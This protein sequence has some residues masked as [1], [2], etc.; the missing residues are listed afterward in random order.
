G[1]TFIDTVDVYGFGHSEELIA[2]VLKERGYPGEV[3]VATKAGNDFH[4]ELEKST[5]STHGRI[6][7]FPRLWDVDLG[8][9]KKGCM[10]PACVCLPKS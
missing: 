3:V 7:T 6:R 8:R 5:N 4:L 1:V 2:A 9:N 10:G